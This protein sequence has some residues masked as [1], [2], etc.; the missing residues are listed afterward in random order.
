MKPLDPNW[1]RG[2]TDGEG[3]FFVGIQKNPTTKSKVQVIPEF[4]IVQHERDIDV[5]YGLKSFF[6]FGIVCRNHDSRF[7]L[8]VRRQEHLRSICDFFDRYPLV[9]KKRIDF[10]KFKDILRL[11]EMGEHLTPDGLKRIAKIAADMNT[12]K[13]NAL[14]QFEELVDEDIVHTSLKDGEEI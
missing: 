7:E 2:F 6:G 5:L 11:M 4:R 13:R 9:T 3:C 8:R 10:L 1:V 14:E 12:G